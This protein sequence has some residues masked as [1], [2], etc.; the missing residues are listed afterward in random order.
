MLF[1]K[2]RKNEVGLRHWEK[3][4]VS[5]GAGTAAPKPTRTY[6]DEG[7][8]NLVPGALTVGLGLHKTGEPFPLIGFENVE[9]DRHHQASQNDDRQGLLQPHASEKQSHDRDG[10]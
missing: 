10:D 2:S 3:R 4:L 6:R 9:S 8:N 7:L 1:G 5:L